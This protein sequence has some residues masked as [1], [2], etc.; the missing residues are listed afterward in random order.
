MKKTVILSILCACCSAFAAESYTALLKQAGDLAK[1]KKYDEAEQAYR[2]AAAAAKNSDETSTALYRRADLFRQQKRYDEAAAAFEEILKVKNLTKHNQGTAWRALA[3]TR[4]L[5]G[6]TR[7]AVRCYK[8]AGS[9][10]AGTWI[11]NVANAELAAICE[12]LGWYEDAFAAHQASSQAAKC[13][14]EGKAAAYAGMVFALAKLGKFKEAHKAMDQLKGFAKDLK[15][16]SVAIS[17]GMAEARLADAEK[18]W[19]HAI[20]GY[21]HVMTLPK[22][23]YLQRRAAGNR[24]AAIALR[25]LKNVELAKTIVAELA[26]SDKYGVSEE[27]KLEIK[28][29]A[30]K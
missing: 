25:E 27:L 14:P 4:M 23:H 12:K 30:K 6:K 2:N 16:L 18:D 19:N 8:A 7:D 3:Q 11:D 20:E 9:V 5:Q 24:A 17:C 21:R 10:K 26:K 22:I 13:P 29:G 15:S 28:K 1:A